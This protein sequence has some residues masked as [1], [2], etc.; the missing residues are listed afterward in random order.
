M[1]VAQIATEF[2]QTIPAFNV[3]YFHR[4]R[5]KEFSCKT[6]LESRPDLRL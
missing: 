6:E 2:H 1:S 3:E 4:C 5:T